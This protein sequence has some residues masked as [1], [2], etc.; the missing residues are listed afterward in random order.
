MQKENL[1][2]EN[3]IITKEMMVNAKTYMPLSLK[4]EIAH[5]IAVQ[6]IQPMKTAE[7]N[8]PADTLISLPQMSGENLA[9]RAACL[10]NTFL[11]FYFDIEIEQSEN[12]YTEYDRLAG[13][14]LLNQIERFKTDKDV[15]DKAYDLLADYREFVKM[16]DMMIATV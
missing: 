14:H 3:L 9:V 7:Q 2:V 8:R 4:E 12:F 5:T 6:S 13:A 16:V 1:S 10:V 15:K 11:G